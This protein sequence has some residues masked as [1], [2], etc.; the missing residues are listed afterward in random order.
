MCDVLL[1]HDRR[2]I[3]INFHRIP[4]DAIRTRENR[5]GSEVLL[6]NGQRMVLGVTASFFFQLA[7]YVTDL[8]EKIQLKQQ[9]VVFS[10]RHFIY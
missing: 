7:N 5:C 6:Y 10:L 8:G 9:T 3:K 4:V 2:R 1:F